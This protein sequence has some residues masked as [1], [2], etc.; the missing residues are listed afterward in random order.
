MCHNRRQKH[1]FKQTNEW[2]KL[3]DLSFWINNGTNF[4]YS[5]TY[6]ESDCRVTRYPYIYPENFRGYHILLRVHKHVVFDVYSTSYSIQKKFF[7]TNKSV[8][9]IINLES[10][11]KT[12]HFVSVST[13]DPDLGFNVVVIIQCMLNY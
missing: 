6:N 7:G 8:V 3:E 11:Y 12:I 13:A 5:V 2:P 4:L 1:N 10:S 9:F